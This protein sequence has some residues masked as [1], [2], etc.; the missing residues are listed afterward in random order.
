MRGSEFLRPVNY[1]K[2]RMYNDHF[3]A[4]LHALSI[5]EYIAYCHVCFNKRRHI[6]YVHLRLYV[7]QKMY[8]NIDLNNFTDSFPLPK[9]A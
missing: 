3:Y 5:S 8:N 9:T 2:T 1:F 7:N 6:F 4:Y